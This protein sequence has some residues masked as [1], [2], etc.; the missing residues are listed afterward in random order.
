MTSQVNLWSTFPLSANDAVIIWL[1]TARSARHAQRVKRKTK[2]ETSF[3]T[4][5][6]RTWLCPP[7]GVWYSTWT[8]NSSSPRGSRR[9]AE[10]MIF[11]G[12]GLHYQKSVCSIIE[13]VPLPY[14][15]QCFSLTRICW[16]RAGPWK[17][18]HTAKPK[19]R[20]HPYQTTSTGPMLF[21]S[22][23]STAHH[24]EQVY[25]SQVASSLC[26][27]TPKAVTQRGESTAAG[28]TYRTKNQSWPS[29]CGGFP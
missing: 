2:R 25:T 14:F 3:I 4:H 29:L 28:C 15:S 23:S 1:L 20:I 9:W 18:L 11:T 12:S 26:W 22:G 27:I 10:Y 6:M 8:S 13:L 7:R 24:Q 21:W 5:V 17:L 19:K 16:W